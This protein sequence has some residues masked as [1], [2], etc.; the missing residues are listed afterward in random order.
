L[1][2][3]GIASEM[4]KYIYIYIYIIK[5]IYYQSKYI[6]KDMSNYWILKRYHVREGTKK[7]PL[8]FTIWKPLVTLVRT[9]RGMVLS[10]TGGKRAWKKH[11]WVGNIYS[12]ITYWNYRVH[13]NTGR[14]W[15]WKARAHILGIRHSEW[16]QGQHRENKEQF[17]VKRLSVIL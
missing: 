16:S 1:H 6:K 11:Y 17:R 14:M 3:G 9:F 15:D 10:E 12:K 13:D 4:S 2:R 8:D 7:C 5:Y